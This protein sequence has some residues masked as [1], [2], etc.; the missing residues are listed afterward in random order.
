MVVDQLSQARGQGH[1][2][3]R[4]FGGIA[5]ASEDAAAVVVA[6]EVVRALPLANLL[7]GRVDLRGKTHSRRSKVALYVAFKP[8]AQQNLIK[9]CFT[10]QEMPD[11]I[12]IT[13]LYQIGSYRKPSYA[14]PRGE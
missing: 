1:R 8:A 11:Q 5:L 13:N 9:I 10:K 2:R 4:L 6:T 12:L 7:T 14:Y 3:P